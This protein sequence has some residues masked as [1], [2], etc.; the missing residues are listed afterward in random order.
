[1]SDIRW[2]QVT[3]ATATA[4]KA[5]CEMKQKD[6]WPKNLI[7]ITYNQAKTQ[8]IIKVDN[9]DQK[10]RTGQA[11]ITDTMKTIAVFDQK[12]LPSLRRLMKTADWKFDWKPAWEPIDGK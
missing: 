3:A 9:A 11:W 10:W 5:A 4:A 8:A 2:F 6:S 12:T 1:M 7:S